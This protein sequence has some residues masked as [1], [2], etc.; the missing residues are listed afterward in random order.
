MGLVK[1]MMKLVEMDQSLL[2][3]PIDE[4]VLWR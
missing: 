4:G 2:N 1:A 3:R